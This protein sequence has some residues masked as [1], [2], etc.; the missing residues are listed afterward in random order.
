MAQELF[1]NRKDAAEQLSLKLLKYQDKNA[2]V[3]GIPRGGM[4]VAWYVAHYL[5]AGLSVLISKKISHPSHPEYGI[6]AV[7][8]ENILHL[9]NESIIPKDI[10]EGHIAGVRYE[11]KRRVNLYRENQP[12]PSMDGKTVIIVDDGIATGVTLLPAMELC[13]RHGAEKIVIAAPVSGKDFEE[14]I[15]KADDLVILHQA[16]DFE[17]VGQFYKNFGQLSD[18]DVIRFLHNHHQ[19]AAL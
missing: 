1:E 13:R 18:E 17:S 3:L 19:R 6:G 15:Y 14:G 4:E 7:C 10:L 12:L 5:N 2:L 16:E 8:E 11:I 9:N